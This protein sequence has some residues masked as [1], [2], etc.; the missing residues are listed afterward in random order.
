MPKRYST[1]LLSAHIKSCLINTNTKINYFT[2]LINKFIAYE[3]QCAGV[4]IQLL[5]QVHLTIDPHWR[6]GQL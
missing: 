6:N 5:R 4:I 1:D 2:A 3:Q